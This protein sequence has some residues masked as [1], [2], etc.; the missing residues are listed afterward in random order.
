MLCACW[1]GHRRAEG[2]RQGCRWRLAAV[3]GR[4]MRKG[5]LCVRAA[6]PV[7]LWTCGVRCR[8]VKP[9]QSLVNCVCSAHDAGGAAAAAG[10]E[11]AANRVCVR[12]QNPTRPKGQ[13]RCGA[14]APRAIARGRRRAAS[15]LFARAVDLASR[16]ARVSR[17]DDSA[18]RA[19]H[20]RP[21]R[22]VRYICSAIVRRFRMTYGLVCGAVAVCS[23]ARPPP[24]T[25]QKVRAYYRGAC[26]ATAQN[27]VSSRGGTLG[28][29]MCLPLLQHWPRASST[30][31]WELESSIG[32][33]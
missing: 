20:T 26:A 32:R 7:C 16:C 6:Q 4:S 31:D 17:R 1:G 5:E 27:R 13:L 23:C 3:V 21:Y 11:H 24:Q 9:C 2:G 19:P 8:G 30:G 29:R 15:G 25:S 10:Q 22:T 14:R 18:R 33:P 28:A 12:S